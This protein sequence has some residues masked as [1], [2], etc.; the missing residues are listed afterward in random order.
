MNTQAQAE[1]QIK[2][3][4]ADANVLKMSSQAEANAQITRAEAEAKAIIRVA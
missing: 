2:K 1:A 3:A 4:E